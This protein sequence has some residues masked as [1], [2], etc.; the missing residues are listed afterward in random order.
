MERLP[1]DYRAYYSGEEGEKKLLDDLVIQ[2]ILKQEAIK[3][4]VDK[5][6]EYKIELDRLKE[7]L[8]VS[9]LVKKKIV[10]GL[11]VS[12]E[13]L[14]NY[15]TEHSEEFIFPES[16]KALHILIKTGEN[17]SQVEKNKARNRALEILKI[18]TP[19]NFRELAKERSEG[20]SGGNGGQLGWFTKDQMVPE[21]SKAAFSGEEGKIYPKIVETVF[22][23]HIIYVEDKQAEEKLSFDDVKEDIKERVLSQKRVDEYNSW[24]DSLK[25]K[26]IKD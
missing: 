22:G 25:T 13:D 10:D 23:F 24:I 9:F 21:F 6:K 5:D 16:V 1:E 19:E 3:E 2:K 26:Y 18:A 7:N 20:P 14:K 4:G 8:L 15:Y 11:D 17:I 12:E